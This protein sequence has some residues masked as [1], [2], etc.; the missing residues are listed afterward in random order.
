MTHTQQT[1]LAAAATVALL[2]A[3]A[4]APA[5]A[6]EDAASSQRERALALLSHE[7][8][9]DVVLL[10]APNADLLRK[11]AISY[12]GEVLQVSEAA[13][14]LVAQL[15]AAEQRR[16]QALGFTVAPATAWLAERRAFVERVLAAKGA[17]LVGAAARARAEHLGAADESIPGFPCYDTVEETLT[18]M[19]AWAK[20]YP[21][22][23]TLID[24]G[25]S[26]VKTQGQGG[27]DL[28]VMKLTSQR[29]GGVKPV[30]L[31][32]TG[33]HAREYAPV[34][35]GTA[36]ASKLLHGYGKDADA[37][38]ILDHH[39]VHLLLQTNPDGRKHAETGLMWRKNANATACTNIHNAQGVDLNR[40]FA[41]SWHTVR[42]GSSGQEC[43]E[44]Y[45]G[46]SAE[47]EPE[48]QALANYVRSLWP[49]NRGP[50]MTDPAS[51]ST[52][53]LHID[54]HSAASL[55]LW[56]WGETR[57]PSGNADAFRTLGRRLAFYNGYTPDVSVGLYPTDGTSDGPPYGELG[58]P[59]YT[60]ELDQT[61][62]EKCGD[63]AA[64]TGPDNVAAL[65]YAAKIVRA[66]YV[67]PAGPDVTDPKLVKAKVQ[68]GKPAKLTAQATDTRFSSRKG[69]EPQQAITA[70][71][72]YIDIPPWMPRAQAIALKAADG[73]FNATTEAVAGELPTA[74]LRK[75][76]HI[77][78]VRARDASQVWGPPSAVFLTVR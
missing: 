44:T 52:T 9:Q 32:N 3:A 75:G 41:F 20:Q 58:V 30:L 57:T 17:P 45:R 67:L 49:D 11:A 47:S 61:F 77:V 40:N 78:Y 26:W 31:L 12:H 46:P 35:V 21:K 1:L 23:V 71:E 60:F 43:A 2:V 59:S 16:V 66:P 56:P 25:D 38:W 36:F 69:T 5:R 70:A 51:L 39:E 13:L 10:R 73:Q 18:R 27:Y 4:T 65:M 19:R 28:V 33:L 76:K 34:A 55:V 29:L 8:L 37:T 54:M 24:I 22:L 50:G 53:G 14:T 42:G 48:T 72:A 62:F 63:F 6:Q 64:K 74:G 15:P 68:A 7:Q